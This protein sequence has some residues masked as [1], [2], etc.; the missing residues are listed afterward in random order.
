MRYLPVIT[1]LSREKSNSQRE[2]AIMNLR[3]KSICILRNKYISCSRVE[4]I[5][6]KWHTFNNK[7]NRV[8][9]CEVKIKI[10]RKEIEQSF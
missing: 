6:I 8:N 10:I 2:L 7:N 1:Q 5:R 3:S 9:L 4:L